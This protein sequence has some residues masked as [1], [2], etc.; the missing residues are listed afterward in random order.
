MIMYFVDKK[1]QIVDIV[2]H[3]INNVYNVLIYFIFMKVDFV[4]KNAQIIPL[5]LNVIK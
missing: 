5:V 1:I 2:I 4:F 3:K